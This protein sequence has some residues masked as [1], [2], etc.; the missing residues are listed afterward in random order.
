M[1]VLFRHEGA[2]LVTSCLRVPRCDAAD[3]RLSWA[4]RRLAAETRSHVLRSRIARIAVRRLPQA[5]L[6]RP[7][8]ERG[9]AVPAGAL[10]RPTC[11]QKMRLCLRLCFSTLALL[12]GV[13]PA[14]AGVGITIDKSIQRMTV[15]VDG[16]TRWRWPVS[17]G[18]RGYDTPNGSYS[19]LRMEKV[20]SSKEWDD[21]P[22]PN[23]IFFTQR[24][25]AIHGSFDKRL[26]KPVS[27][28][29]VR[30]SPGNAAKLY[31]LVESQGVANTKVLVSGHI[32]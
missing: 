6:L 20:Y 27:H 15:A 1:G 5:A 18:A 8:A 17:T 11:E 12:I 23:S 19:A 22:M 16:T 7:T 25:H 32:K 4:S 14:A 30:L 24:G 9:S 10:D 3:A 29:C 21:A 13:L 26:G 31:S 2:A 28:G